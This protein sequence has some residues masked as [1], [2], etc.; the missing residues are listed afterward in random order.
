MI[1][2]DYSSNTTSSKIKKVDIN[3]SYEQFSRQKIV[4]YEDEISIYPPSQVVFIEEK[5]QKLV[6]LAEGGNSDMMDAVAGS[7]IQ[8]IHRFP[9][10]IEIGVK[11]LKMCIRKICIYAH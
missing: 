1:T 5:C 11:F 7:L 2:E 4:E 10:N 6:K 8:R 3:E 9:K